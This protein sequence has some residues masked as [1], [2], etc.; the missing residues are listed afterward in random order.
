MKSEKQALSTLHADITLDNTD[1]NLPITQQLTK[2]QNDLAA[3]NKIMN[4][5][6]E[7]TQKTKVLD[8][9]PKNASTHIAKLE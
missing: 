6:A 9:T 3:E 2:L 7:Q 5:L 8:E 4:V 1:L